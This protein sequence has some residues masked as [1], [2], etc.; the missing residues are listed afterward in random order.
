MDY[1]VFLEH[2]R[3]S[4]KDLL[5]NSV[6]QSPKI[7]SIKVESTYELPNTDLRVTRAFKTKCRTLFLDTTIN[8]SLDKDFIKIIQEEMI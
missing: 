6:Q 3:H 5:F 1:R 8:N 7:Y 2:T 4:I